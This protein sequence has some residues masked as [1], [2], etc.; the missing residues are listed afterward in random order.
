MISTRCDWVQR[1]A[2]LTTISLF[3]AGYALLGLVGVIVAAV[4]EGVVERRIPWHRSR[5]DSLLAAL[6][7][8]FFISGL[9][10]SYRLIAVGE[11]MLLTLSIYFT[12]GPLSQLLYRDG[13]FLTP[14]LWAWAGGGVGAAAWGILGHVFTKHPA[15][16][17]AIGPTALGTT[18]LI[19]IGVSVGLL[20]TAESGWTFLRLA[21]G[22]AVLTLGLA[23]TY[24]RGAWGGT[25]VELG[26]FFLLADLRYSWRA[27]LLLILIGLAGATFV[28]VVHPA[29][30]PAVIRR[31]EGTTFSLAATHWRVFLALSAVAIF[32][33]HPV[34]GTGLGTFPLVYPQYRLP[35]DPNPLP[36]PFAHNIFLNVAAEGG[37][38]G[39]GAFVAIIGWALVAG[40]RWHAQS[41]SP[42]DRI[43]SAAVLSTFIGM[44]THQ[45]FDGTIQS[46]HLGAGLWFLIAI[47]GAR[48]KGT[49]R[50]TVTGGAGREAT[51]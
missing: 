49:G 41:R 31:V 43:V 8:I 1:A 12:F 51:S 34:F 17:Q 3:S 44:L 21:A 22:M 10:S 28:A 18:L 40:W 35:G 5:V 45:L 38:L 27:L 25:I 20:S 29:I 39:L 42:S 30:D 4:A 46:V 37:A 32:R 50:L 2:L 24:S 11:A 19:A 48:S 36:V 15:S 23:L 6:V 14:F 33:S 26:I 7:V 13:T 16:T 47:L 9:L